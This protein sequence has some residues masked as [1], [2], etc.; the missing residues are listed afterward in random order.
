MVDRPGFAATA[1]PLDLDLEPIF[2]N[3][4]R[5][6]EK[7]HQ[8]SRDRVDWVTFSPVIQPFP[9]WR[10]SDFLPR[11][12]KDRV[13]KRFQRI[14]IFLLVRLHPHSSGVEPAEP[15]DRRVQR[16]DREPCTQTTTPAGTLSDPLCSV[17][18]VHHPRFV[19]FLDL[20]AAV[21]A[22]IDGLCGRM[23]WAIDHVRPLKNLQ[24]VTVRA[25]DV[26]FALIAVVI[27][28]V[29]TAQAIQCRRA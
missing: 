20:G 9:V 19:V 29:D 10:V 4:H 24:L 16:V 17:V 1:P 18:L 2:L 15:T 26:I 25:R 8:L 13:D 21:L 12:A 11:L 22:C 28:R 3:V 14:L 23:L 6:G 7:Q 27:C 5:C